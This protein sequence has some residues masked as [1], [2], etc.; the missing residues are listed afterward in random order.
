[1]RSTVTGNNQLR[2]PA[3]LARK[4]GIE[5]GSRVAWEETDALIA[6]S[7]H[8][9]S[10]TLVHRDSHFDAIP[11]ALLDTLRLPPR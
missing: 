2:I 10:V 6:G 4:L 9:H 1:M 11:D 7:A 3:A 8:V 5:R